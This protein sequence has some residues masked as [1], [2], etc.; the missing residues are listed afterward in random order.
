MLF[1][2]WVGW[3]HP[4]F[5]IIF[6]F[7]VYISRLI[8][9]FVPPSSLLFGMSC[10]FPRCLLLI[11]LRVLCYYSILSK[12]RV[13]YNVTSIMNPC[14]VFIWWRYILKVYKMLCILYILFY[15]MNALRL[16][17]GVV[18]WWHHSY[19]VGHGP[20]IRVVTISYA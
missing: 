11:C 18:F 9:L 8:L 12:V 5:C 13:L 7:L 3:I 6:M 15:D 19:V 4:S 2:Y 20:G 16:S 17:I 10:L 14:F 1:S